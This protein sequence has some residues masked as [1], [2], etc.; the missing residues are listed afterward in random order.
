MPPLTES[1]SLNHGNHFI[2]NKLY[3]N[4]PMTTHPSLHQTPQINDPSFLLQMFSGAPNNTP[5]DEVAKLL[6]KVNLQNR[7]PNQIEQLLTIPPMQNGSDPYMYNDVSSSLS[8]FVKQPNFINSQY[9][10]A[11]TDCKAIPVD[12]YSK[13]DRYPPGPS[14]GIVP[15]AALMDTVWTSKNKDRIP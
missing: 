8:S 14:W 2:G 15:Q 1:L 9:H 7:V 4:S 13:H 11:Q 5:P 10:H 3:S 6:H 12:S